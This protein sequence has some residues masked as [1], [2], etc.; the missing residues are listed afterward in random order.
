MKEFFFLL[1]SFVPTGFLSRKVF[2]NPHVVGCTCFV[3]CVDLFGYFSVF[4]VCV[5]ETTDVD[6]GVLLFYTG[7]FYPNKKFRKREEVV[8][9]S[10]VLTLS[11]Q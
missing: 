10:S 6:M 9:P 3:L 2:F 5:R 7:N 8:Y 1:E 4:L 11:L